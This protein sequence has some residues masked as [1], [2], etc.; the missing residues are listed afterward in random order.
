MHA[1]RCWPTADNVHSIEMMPPQGERMQIQLVLMNQASAF[2]DNLQT[3]YNQLLG[4]SLPT[5]RSLDTPGLHQLIF[6]I[7]KISSEPHSGEQM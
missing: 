4:C 1:V 2:R 6:H 5:G 7:P 3:S